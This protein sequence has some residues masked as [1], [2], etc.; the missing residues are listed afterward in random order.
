MASH[1]ILSAALALIAVLAM[2]LLS[3]YGW[4]VAAR[5]GIGTPRRRKGALGLEET[6]TLDSRRRLSLVSCEGRRLL[7]LTGGASDVVVGWLPEQ[8]HPG[9]A[10]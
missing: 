5:L 9:D 10:P 8:T 4:Q 7:L 1:D 6:L 3:R 2:I